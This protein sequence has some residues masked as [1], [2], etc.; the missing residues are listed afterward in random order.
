LFHAVR[1]RNVA[2]VADLIHAGTDISVRSRAD[3]HTAADLARVDVDVWA[4][5]RSNMRKV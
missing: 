5:M 2:L 1:T 4:T 3:E